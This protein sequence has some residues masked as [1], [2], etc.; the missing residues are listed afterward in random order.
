MCVCVLLYRLCVCVCVDCIFLRDIPF[1]PLCCVSL[2]ASCH[3]Q[4]SSV[5]LSDRN[6]NEI[7]I[8]DPLND[9]PSIYIFK[10]HT[11]TSCVCTM[12]FLPSIQSILSADDSGGLEVWTVGGAT[13]QM[14]G[15]TA[16]IGVMP[17]PSIHDVRFSS[18]VETDLFELQ[19]HTTCA[20][21]IS[22]SPRGD[23]FAVLCRDQ[24]VRV[25]RTS[26]CKL[27]RKYDESVE[28]YQSSQSDPHM[29]SLHL[30]SLDFG[31]RI[32]SEKELRR[33][34]NINR[35][36]TCVFD[37]SGRL[38]IIPT[39]IGIKVLSIESNQLL[40]VI[41]KGELGERLL[42]ISLYQGLSKKRRIHAGALNCEAAVTEN[43]PI[44]FCTSMSKQ[45]F[46]LFT[47][48]EP[49]D[50]HTHTHTHT[51]SMTDRDVLNEKPPVS[52]TSAAISAVHASSVRSKDVREA[53]I[54]TT[55]GD[56]VVRLYNKECPKTVENFCEHARNGYYDNCRFHR[57]IKGFMIQT[58]DPQGDGTGGESI[59]G[60]EFEDE[61]HKSLKHDRPYTL[62]MA[63]AGPNTNGSQFFITTVP[64]SWLDGKHTVFGRATAG[65][66]TILAIENV[67]VNSDDAPYKDIKILAIKIVCN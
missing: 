4:L 40:R 57:V 43:E 31:R 14:D 11:H 28:M 66:D 56:I 51:S 64:C 65:V 60:G 3:Q 52:E 34:S 23:L 59:W 61:F 50:T 55:M 42:C 41:G 45:R 38:I 63:N 12:C 49:E 27:I 19:K 1:S 62:S 32:A 47:R 58:G 22:V 35:L 17:S 16:P 2:D 39:L 21:N 18:K 10:G 44:L 15:E 7:H 5:A 54:H 24:F 46:F 67:R 33:E 9:T 29:S 6:S 20:L 48:K 53:T 13:A 25:F 26:T 30:D 8:L 37:N 36:Q